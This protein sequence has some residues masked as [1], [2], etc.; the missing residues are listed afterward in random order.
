M[1]GLKARASPGSIY[2]A[3]LLQRTSNSSNITNHSSALW[4]RTV[5]Q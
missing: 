1:L 4:R 5:V 2:S 3:A